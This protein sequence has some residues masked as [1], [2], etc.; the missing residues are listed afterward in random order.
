M[1]LLELVDEGG[2]AEE[3]LDEAGEG[4]AAGGEDLGAADEVGQEAIPGMGMRD[5]LV[6]RREGMMIKGET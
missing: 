3:T 5:V 4:A 1:L 6:W 2:V